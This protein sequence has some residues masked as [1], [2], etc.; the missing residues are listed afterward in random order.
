[1]IVTAESI[2]QGKPFS[3]A[4]K[5]WKKAEKEQVRPHLFLR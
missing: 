2:R 5:E 1:V 3:A 4:E